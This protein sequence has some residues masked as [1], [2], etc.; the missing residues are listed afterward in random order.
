MHSGRIV[1]SQSMDDLPH[2]DGR[3]AT[4]RWKT[5]HILWFS[6]CRNC[7]QTEPRTCGF[8]K[9]ISEHFYPPPPCQGRPYFLLTGGTVRLLTGLAK[10]ATTAA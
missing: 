2:I 4:Y 10:I 9:S 8:T 3:P 5:C 6:A 7:L 1:F